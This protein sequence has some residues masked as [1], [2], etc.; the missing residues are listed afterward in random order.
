MSQILEDDKL[1]E[2]LVTKINIYTS[3]RDNESLLWHKIWYLVHIV[4][5]LVNLLVELIQDLGG[6]CLRFL[7]IF[8]LK[9]FICTPKVFCLK[10]ILDGYSYSS[11]CSA[12]L[13][14]FTDLNIREILSTKYASSG[15]IW[16]YIPYRELSLDMTCLTV[17][18]CR[19]F[20]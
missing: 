3:L 15:T 10:I 8:L 4:I 9:I 16:T 17:W 5:F 7:K 20:G 12:Y 2:P 6:G 13:I 1:Y 18:P 14:T 19:T 11:K